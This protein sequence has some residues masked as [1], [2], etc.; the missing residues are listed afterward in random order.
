MSVL[1][2]FDFWLLFPLF[3]KQ[4]WPILSSRLV[5]NRTGNLLVPVFLDF[6]FS[7]GFNFRQL[8]L[9]TFVFSLC[10]IRLGTF[11]F[12]FCQLNHGTFV[13]GFLQL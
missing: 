1:W 2:P 8:R 7:F 4:V 3:A 10:Q 9:G 6:S 12:G 5:A 11:V 13:F